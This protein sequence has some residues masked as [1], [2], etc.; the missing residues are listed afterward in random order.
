[1][2]CDPRSVRSRTSSGIW[3]CAWCITRSPDRTHDRR[4]GLVPGHVAR[5]GGI[6]MPKSLKRTS[7]LRHGVSVHGLIE[8]EEAARAERMRG[9]NL[10]ALLLLH[11]ALEGLLS[12]VRGGHKRRENFAELI[13]AY[14]ASLRGRNISEAKLRRTV[15]SLSAFNKLRN[16]VIHVWLIRYGFKRA[17][18]MLRRRRRTGFRLYLSILKEWGERM[19]E[20]LAASGAGAKRP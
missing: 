13:P 6:P 10:F 20:E 7:K 11:A 9:N 4:R 15:A 12:S 14:G 1:M 3:N 2:T 18:L 8:S 16:T 5:S 19:N 17:N